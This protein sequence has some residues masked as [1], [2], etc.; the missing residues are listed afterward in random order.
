ME[1]YTGI[2]E[3]VLENDTFFFLLGRAVDGDGIFL[4]ETQRLSLGA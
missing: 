4:V 2:F 3:S 1:D